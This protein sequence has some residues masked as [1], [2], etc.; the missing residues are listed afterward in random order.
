MPAVRAILVL[1]AALLAMANATPAVSQG[2]NPNLARNLAATCANCHGANGVSLGG[3]ASL[4]GKPKDD[5]ARA[6]REFKAGTR[7]ATVMTQLA[8]GYSDEQIELIAG[9]FALQKPDAK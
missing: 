1:P 9:W 8:K 6:M 2:S 4:A 7:P 5:L 3:F